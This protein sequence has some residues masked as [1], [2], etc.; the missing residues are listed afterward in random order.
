MKRGLFFAVLALFA[1][2]CSTRPIGGETGRQIYG[3]AGLPGVAGVQG[4]IGA[5]QQWT[6][7]RN[8]LFDVD[9]SDLRTEEA[10]KVGEIVAYMEQNPSVRIGI[11]GHTDPRGTNRYN[12]TLSERR[13]NAIRYALVKAGGSGD[14]IQTGAFGG[15]RPA[16]AES[17]EACWPRD[18]R[19]EVLV[20]GAK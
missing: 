11:D 6:A 5:V 2:G 7:F 19:V 12:Q 3:P 15:Q 10:T 8:F 18:R 13:V 17:T 20:R 4:P 1:V 14:R 16:C 9:K